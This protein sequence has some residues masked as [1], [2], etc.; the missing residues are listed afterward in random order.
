M[1]ENHLSCYIYV[2]K[3][4]PDLLAT[5]QSATGEFEQVLPMWQQVKNLLSI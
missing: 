5:L 2:G 3:F 4:K 1:T